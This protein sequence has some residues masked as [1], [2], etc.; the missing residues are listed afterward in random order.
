MS[1]SWARTNI[2]TMVGVQTVVLS[3]LNISPIFKNGQHP[4]TSSLE[5]KKAAQ[6]FDEA[7]RRHGALYLTGTG[8]PS[9]L[10]SEL[11]SE[12]VRFFASSNASKHEWAASGG[13][14]TEGYTS[15]GQEAVARSR[16]GK[17]E[18]RDPVESL[19][20][21]STESDACPPPLRKLVAAYMN[22]LK[23]VHEVLTMLMSSGLGMTKPDVED[24]FIDPEIAIKLANYPVTANTQG[25]G[26]HTDFTGFTLLSQDDSDSFP[27]QGSLQIQL[28]DGTW[29]NVPPV[30]GSLVVNAGDMIKY[31]SNGLYKSPV[32]R[33]VLASLRDSPRLSVVYFTSPADDTIIE[34]H[35][36]C[37]SE[38]NP[39][40]FKTIN[41][42]E[43]LSRK[44]NII[45]AEAAVP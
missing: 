31:L 40:R 16:S 8:V 28:D 42:G 22:H 41:A 23:G 17:T 20:F 3:E 10:L 13:Y 30:S 5:F 35:S 38:E 18:S 2:F 39:A 9:I 7:M 12:A 29:A 15:I 4:D 6:V 11:R 14:G 34:P 45:A 32:H 33:V 37:C 44:L 21:K 25:Y 1:S 27:A 43:W 36:S 19:V 26:E 24:K